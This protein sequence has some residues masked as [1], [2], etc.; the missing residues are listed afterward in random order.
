MSKDKESSLTLP[1]LQKKHKEWCSKNFD[2]REPV[3]DRKVLHCAM[4]VAEEAGELVHSILKWD[5]GIRGSA[6]Q[7]E[8][9]AKD[10]VGDVTL[11]LLDLCNRMGWDYEE[12]LREVA[13]EVHKR[14]W[15]EDR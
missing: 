2:H 14:D 4:N 10:A 6:S 9:D 1:T 8:A 13:V 15:T 7:H 12:I 3:L 5:Q 11:C